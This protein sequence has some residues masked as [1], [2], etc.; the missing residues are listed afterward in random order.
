MKKTLAALALATSLTTVAA[1]NDR[2][3][4]ITL[5]VPDKITSPQQPGQ[6]MVN[7]QATLEV[8]PDCADLTI[9]L[10]A[11]S[12]R[13]GVATKELEAKKQKLI[14][15][16]DKI[17]VETKDVKLSTLSLD[18]IFEQNEHGWQ[19]TK[20]S[21]YRAQITVTATTRDFSKIADILDSAGN[22]GASSMSTQFRRSDM[23]ELKK[24]VRDMALKAAKE[25]ANQTATTLGS[26]T[27]RTSRRP[28]RS[29]SAT[30]AS[31]SAARSSRSRSTSRSASSSRRRPRPRSR[32]SAWR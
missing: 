12:I 5:Q 9:T 21:T 8:S 4:V 27:R 26:G 31:R 32:P 29:T 30:P 18:P 3:Q 28:T 19:M 6:M 14:A 20:V 25:K 2:P 10:T 7:G 17:G 24:Q 23:A 16:L 11:D 13:P 15:A 22:A 1:C